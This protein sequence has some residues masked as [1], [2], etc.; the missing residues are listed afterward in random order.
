MSAR[1]RLFIALASTSLM[2]YIALGSLLGRVLGDTTYGQL[3]VFNE[4]VRMVLEA[5]VEPVN[6][7]RAM[8]GARLGLTEALDGDSAYLDAEEFKTIQTP[9]KDSDADVGLV[10]SRRLSFLMVISTRPGSPAEKAG[11]RPGDIV[12]TI[13]GRHTRPVSA[14]VG[15]RLLRGAP[16]SVV[17]MTLLRAASD[18]IDVSM[19]RERLAPLPVQG[20]MLEGGSGYVKVSE[21]S[22]RTADEV[23]GAI[24]TLRKSGAQ[25]IVLD[26]RSAAGSPENGVKVAELFLKGGV[27]A[28]LSGAK[29]PE[30]ILSA[31]PA[32][33]AWDKPLAVLL[34]H[35]STGAAEIVAAAMLDAGRGPVVG[36]R[37]FGR[38]PVQKTIPLEQGGLVITVA[39]YASPK[40]TA[41]HGKGIEPSVLVESADEDDDAG[42]SG[43]TAPQKATDPILDKAL[44]VLR[45]PVKKAA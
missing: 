35:G 1:S 42:E 10:L 44:E 5:Y 11:V 41:I 7:D 17:K 9:M 22:P 30:Q 24:E 14:P 15:Q 40:G 12:K 32:R 25:N 18:P 4:V 43:T 21:V 26:L 33:Q 37:T 3:A 28:K 13:D 8:A 2:A 16:G 29:T 36:E 45:A 31:D 27:V 20:R 6:V 23:R 39:R 19:V 34:D 38:A